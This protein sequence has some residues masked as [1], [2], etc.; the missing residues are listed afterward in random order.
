LKTFN[1]E[2]KTADNVILFFRYVDSAGTG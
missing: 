1:L 2:N